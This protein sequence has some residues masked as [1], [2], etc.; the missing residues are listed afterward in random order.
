MANTYTKIFLQFVFRIKWKST[1]IPKEF[2]EELHKYITGLVQNRRHLLLAIY[3]M[4]DHIHI[5]VALN[6][7]QSISNLLSEIKTGSNKFI[8]EK[9]KFSQRF[10]WQVGYG[11]FS[12]S[13][14]AVERV[15]RYI[16]NQEEHHRKKSFSDEYLEFLKEF[17]IEYKPEY[18]FHEP[19]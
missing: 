14:D 12:Y 7:E 5:L 9:L 3:A 13:P 11:A 10:E 2:Q 16:N 19:L 15:K 6:P 17:E 4:P 18:L 8:N 1:K